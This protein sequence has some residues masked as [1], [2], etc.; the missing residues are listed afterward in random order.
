MARDDLPEHVRAV[1]ARH[2]DSVQQVE[3]LALM[4]AEPA[5]AWTTPEFCKMLQLTPAACDA[6]VRRLAAGGMVAVQEESVRLTASDEDARAL[7]DLLDLYGRRRIS[8]V[9]SIYG[10]RVD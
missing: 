9:D 6:W 2:I 3:I 4:R 10:G 7:D 8:V 1:I 5:R